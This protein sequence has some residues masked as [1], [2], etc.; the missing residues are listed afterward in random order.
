MVDFM[1]TKQHILLFVAFFALLAGALM[2]TN[3]AAI[4]SATTTTEGEDASAL[5]VLPI[6]SVS[7]TGVGSGMVTSSPA[8]ITCG[9][10]CASAF[11]P[12]TLV[13]L[14]AAADP[15][16]T[17][18]GWSGG[19]CSG[20]D[21]C[22]MTI[23]ADTSVSADFTLNSYTLSVSK[24]GVG[25][26]MVTSSPAGITCG[27][28]CAHAFTAGTTVALTASPSPD[29]YFSS[30][31]GGGCFGNGICSMIMTADTTVFADFRKELHQL[32][33]SLIWR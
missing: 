7:K 32:F 19:G 4:T 29:S 26:G 16:S 3:A 11:P 17:F 14:T 12:G 25:S 10:E 1:N 24:T 30:W 6:L 13:S 33:L 20:T 22:S 5:D 28:V 15:V 21:T 9:A 31:S 2:V 18:T 8:G 27:A 23:T